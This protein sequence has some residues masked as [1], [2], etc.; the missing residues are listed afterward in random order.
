MKTYKAC[1]EKETF[2]EIWKYPSDN[3]SNFT[4]KFNK[5]IGGKNAS[6]TIGR[7]SKKRAIKL[8]QITTGEFCIRSN[9]QNIIKNNFQKM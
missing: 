6:R 5:N 4:P 7:Q 3:K 8:I 1:G 2:V 9:I